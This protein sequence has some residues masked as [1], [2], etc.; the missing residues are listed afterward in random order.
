[1]LRPVGLALR[2]KQLPGGFPLI[3]FA[4]L[5]VNLHTHTDEL[6]DLR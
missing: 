3:S 2:A 1:M 6:G 4:V 5:S